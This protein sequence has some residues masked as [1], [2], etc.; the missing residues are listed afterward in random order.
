[1]TEFVIR[2]SSGNKRAASL[3]AHFTNAELSGASLA[4]TSLHHD[5][6]RHIWVGGA[7]NF[8]NR[9]Q[10]LGE[11]GLDP[12]AGDQT[13]ICAGW[14]RW[15]HGLW[16]RLR[17]SFALFLHDEMDASSILARDAFGLEPLYYSKSNQSLTVSNCPWAARLMAGMAP[18]RSGRRIAEFLLGTESDAAGTYYAQLSRLPPAHSLTSKG[19]ETEIRRYW[20]IGAVG[21][22]ENPADAAEHFRAL[23]DRS[24]ANA[25]GNEHRVGLMLSGGLDSSALLASCMALP[26]RVSSLAAFSKT[27]YNSP[28]WSDG[29]YLAQLR[30]AYGLEA[31]ELAYETHHPL[32]NMERQMR[33]LDGPTLAYG[34]SSSVAL[35][36]MARDAGQHIV[37]NGHG[38][39]EIVSYGS[40]R[41]NELAM[42]GRWLE[43]WLN[44]GP[45]AQLHGGTRAQIFARYLAHK[46]WLRPLARRLGARA[47]LEGKGLTGS[48]LQSDLEAALESHADSPKPAYNRIDHDERMIQEEALNSPMQPHSLETIVLSSRA[49]GVETRMPF[50]DRELAEFSLS[51]ASRHKLDGGQT[52]A[53]LRRAMAGRLPAGLLRRADKFDFYPSFL[54]ALFADQEPLRDWTRPGDPRLSEY[55]DPAW[56]ENFWKNL[57]E[58]PRQCSR[59]DVMAIWRI[60]TLSMWLASRGEPPRKLETL[61]REGGVH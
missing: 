4:G 1:M 8:S 37:L 23:F 38:G 33:V 24:V 11:L 53:I 2:L 50:Y 61:G 27:F 56:L 28:E 29:E 19:G 17:G 40:G 30:S 42:E 45:V 58:D 46:P 43:L 9:A 6:V 31:S 3:P 12:G 36:E 57:P 10:M 32:L 7:W 49:A 39:D 47:V 18:E 20:N 52:R 54:A 60:A 13:L 44:T 35:L 21:R 59:P 41:L 55:V 34:L 22:G 51:L 48:P 26:G 15:Q 14:R 25:V 16:G 5:P